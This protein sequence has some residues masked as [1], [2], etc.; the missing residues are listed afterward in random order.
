MERVPGLSSAHKL[1]LLNLAAS[2]LPEEEAYL[3]VGSWKGQSIIA[4]M[5]ENPKSHFYAVES[6][7]GFGVP[8][9]A[10][11]T[12]LIDNLSRWGVKTRLRLLEGDAFKLLRRAQLTAEPVGVYFYDADHRGLGHYLALG[13]A[14]PH[15]AEDALVIIDDTASRVVAKAIDRYVSRHPGYE[16]LLELPAGHKERVWWN[17]LRV[18]RFERRRARARLARPRP[19]LGWRLVPYSLLHR[20]ATFVFGRLM[21]QAG[22]T[23]VREMKAIGRDG[24]RSLR[25][26][27]IFAARMA[28]GR[29]LGTHSLHLRAGVRGGGGAQVRARLMRRL[30]RSMAGGCGAGLGVW[31]GVETFRS[32]YLHVHGN[33]EMGAGKAIL[34]AVFSLSFGVL[35]VKIAVSL[36]DPK[37]D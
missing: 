23:L 20:P 34:A 21:P 17:G 30:G 36:R 10:T 25:R 9:G 3:E 14:E 8:K 37:V 4:A 26:L 12:E 32:V 2:L 29:K 27:R 1:A 35:M 31:A 11:R 6:F 24:S 16:L 18:Y 22:P 13:L 19:D 28:S 15:L 5:L 7:R 33:N